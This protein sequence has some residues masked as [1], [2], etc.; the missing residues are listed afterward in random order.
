MFIFVTDETAIKD[1][2]ND[3]VNEDI[4][5]EFK[6]TK[7]PKYRPARR[8]YATE[9]CKKNNGSM[10]ARKSSRFV[11]K[12]ITTHLSDDYDTFKKMYL[13]ES[14]H[15]NK[16]NITYSSSVPKLVSSDTSED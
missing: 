10:Y 6:I 5:L 2:L 7:V 1:D 3:S 13:T 4:I 9:A 14:R 15:K 11:S 12:K 8:W 16:K